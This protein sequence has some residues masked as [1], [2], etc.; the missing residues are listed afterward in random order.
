MVGFLAASLDALE[1]S[2][3]LFSFV[4]RPDTGQYFSLGEMTMPQD[5]A[6]TDAQKAGGI[7]EI[8]VV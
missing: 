8:G 1:L 2:I 7:K 5:K 4:E 3:F 6:A